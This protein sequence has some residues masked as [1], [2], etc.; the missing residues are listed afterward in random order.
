[1]AERAKLAVGELSAETVSSEDDGDTRGRPEER[2]RAEL[3]PPMLFSGPSWSSPVSVAAAAAATNAASSFGLSNDGRFVT[4]LKS[5][6]PPLPTRFSG[7]D[8]LLFR[9]EL[10]VGDPPVLLVEGDVASSG[11][12]S[13]A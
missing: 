9:P 3:P 6:L 1:L 10:R 2:A 4:V 5:E 13:A 8:H 12:A 7:S 11:A